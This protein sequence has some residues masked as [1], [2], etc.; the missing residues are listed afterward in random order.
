[1][2][3]IEVYIGQRGEY[4]EQSRGYNGHYRGYIGQRWEYI[5]QSR[6]YNGQN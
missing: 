1:M 2:D 5:E 3:K 4:I 6:G